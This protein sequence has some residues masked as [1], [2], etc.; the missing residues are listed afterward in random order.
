MRESNKKCPFLEEIKVAY[1]KAYPIKKM[2]P[3]ASLSEN[4]C[5]NLSHLNCPVYNEKANESLTIHILSMGS[6]PCPFFEESNMVYCKVFPIK[7]MIPISAVQLESCCTKEAHIY[8]EAFMEM[9]EGDRVINVRGFQL[10]SDL[11]YHKGHTWLKKEENK[12]KIG[13]DHFASSLLGNI[14]EFIT[15]SPGERVTL[16]QPLLCVRS[17]RYTAEPISP[18]SG[19]VNEVNEL[20]LQNPSL[21][22]RTPYDQGWLLSLKPSVIDETL[23][24]GIRAKE[25]M[26]KEVERFHSFLEKEIGVTLTDGGEMIKDLSQRLTAKEWNLL[27]KTFL[28]TKGG[29]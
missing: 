8:C 1:C 20:I 16:N 15:P 25:W 5:S 11:L 12:V 27:M 6:E 14:D 21:I 4:P 26:E 2:I 24:S 28:R 23:I 19:E 18:V 3:A 7:K 29:V 13:F 17:G 22:Q 10:R 9:V